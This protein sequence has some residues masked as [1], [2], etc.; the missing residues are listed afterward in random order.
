M[1]AGMG[2]LVA[3]KPKHLSISEA[4][5]S[6]E[7]T[8][9]GLRTDLGLTLIRNSLAG[10]IR[11]PA[12]PRAALPGLAERN[13]SGIPVPVV[14]RDHSGVVSSGFPAQQGLG[15]HPALPAKVAPTLSAARIIFGL[16]LAE[17]PEHRLQRMPDYANFPTR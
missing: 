7:I 3:R 15:G 17:G 13:P 2:Y 14:A 4:A 6:A 11:A 9:A 16:G 12:P 8:K 5:S 10:G 1:G